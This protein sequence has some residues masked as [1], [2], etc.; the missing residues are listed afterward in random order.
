VRPGETGRIITD[1]ADLDA[2]AE[3]WDALAAPAVSPMQQYAWARA[4]AATL[5][6]RRE[7]HVVAVNETAGLAVAPLVRCRDGLGRMEFLGALELDE[8]ADVLAADD[9]ALARLADTLVRSGQPLLLK[10]IPAESPLVPALLSAYHGRGLVMKRRLCGFPWIPLDQDWVRPEGRLNPGRRSDLRRARRIAEAIGPVHF[11]VRAP[12]PGD[13]SPVLR[14]AFAVE[15]ASWKGRAGSALA[16][17]PVRQAFFRRYADAACRRGILRVGFLRIGTTPVAMQL[18]VEWG[19]RF[20]L[21]KIGFDEAFSRCSP[22]T[23]LMAE[24]V[25]R[26]AAQGL[27]SFELLGVSEPWTRM[28]T[29]LERPCVSLRAYPANRTGAVALATDLAR[30]GFSRVAAALAVCGVC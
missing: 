10:R 17:D 18:G 6:G 23:L 9:V 19:G 24:M 20:W 27:S 15:A 14:E 21:L 4:C 3:A 16:C 12:S 22:G 26:A 25:A 8:P 11:E 5:T 13:L 28:W 30:A 29:N 7:L 1:V 2:L